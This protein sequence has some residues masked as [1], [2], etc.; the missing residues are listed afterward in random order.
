M[1]VGIVKGGDDMIKIVRKVL[2][3]FFLFLVVIVIATN[4]LRCDHEN[5]K[6]VF[7]FDAYDSSAAYN[8][9]NVICTDCNETL[10]QTLFHKTPEDKSYLRNKIMA[11][12]LTEE[13]IIQ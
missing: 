1:V 13:N 8:Y 3:G 6:T 2:I 11:T 9:S 5:V 7:S 12:K 4:I 10:K